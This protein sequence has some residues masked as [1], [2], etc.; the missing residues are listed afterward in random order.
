[1]SRFPVLQGSETLAPGALDLLNRLQD[2]QRPPPPGFWPPAPGW[3]LLAALLCLLAAVL[4]AWSWH[5]HRTRQPGRQ[6]LRELR[7]WQQRAADRPPAR[8]AAELSALLKRLALCHYPDKQVAALSGQAWLEFLDASG[9]D[10]SFTRGPGRALG[11]A[12]FQRDFQL[13]PDALAQVCR[14]WIIAQL[15]RP[16][17]P[18]AARS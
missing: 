9:P 6:A 13:D 15:K 10:R 8:A 7:A 4:A 12:R 1:M 16:R 17:R 18:H 5:R 14:A 11:D 3:I 2:I